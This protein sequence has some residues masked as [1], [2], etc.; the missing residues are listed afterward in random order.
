MLAPAALSMI[1]DS[2]PAEKRTRPAGVFVAS[3]AVGISV[4]FIGGA[5]LISATENIGLLTYSVPWTDQVSR[6]LPWQMAFILAAAPG[7]LVALMLLFTKEPKRRGVLTSASERRQSSAALIVTVVRQHVPTYVALYGGMALLYAFFY[8][9]LSWLPTLFMR[10]FGMPQAD[11]GRWF[12]VASLVMSV[13][14]MI[15]STQLVARL[16]SKGRADAHLRTVLIFTVVGAPLMLLGALS[17]LQAV[18]FGCFIPALFFLIG[19]VAIPQA[20]MQIIVPNQ[21]RAQSTAMYHFVMNAIGASSGP[22]LVAAISEAVL[23]DEGALDA[24]IVLVGVVTLPL[25]AWIFHRSLKD[26]GAS[27]LESKKWDGAPVA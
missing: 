23:Q 14:G 16:Q 12:G 25:A 2:F 11:F 22:L 6:L 19:L 15:G 18:A 8:G 26:F 17:P 27:V 4:A 24:A 13:L 10:K 21:I 7:P 1:A 5:A 3:G 9:A 20:A